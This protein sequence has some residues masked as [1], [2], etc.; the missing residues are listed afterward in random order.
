LLG[1][2]RFRLPHGAHPDAREVAP[3]AA[4][5][6]C[7]VD[8]H[9]WRRAHARLYRRPRPRLL[10]HDGRSARSQQPGGDQA[11]R[12]DHAQLHA[13]QRRGA[14]APLAEAAARAGGLCGR[15]DAL[16][17]AARLS[18]EADPPGRGGPPVRHL[19]VRRRP[20]ELGAGPTVQGA[21]SRQPVRRGRELLPVE[22]VGQ[23]VA[24]DHR[25]RAP[26]RRSSPRAPR[27]AF[28]A[29]DP[30]GVVAKLLEQTGGRSLSTEHAAVR[31]IPGREPGVP[32]R[33]VV[34]FGREICGDL[35]SAL[36]REWL[37]TNG[38]G[39]YASGTLAGINARRYHG[40]LVAALTP[41][42]GRTVLVGGLV[43]W[44]GYGGGRYPLSTHE[45]VD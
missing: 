1:R 37:V 24:D 40:L 6:G 9:P 4:R 12:P 25:Q 5:R 27:A 17:P 41:P 10:D 20:A 32:A 28:G 3:R 18:L 8:S 19:P 13:E 34:S 42:V 35:A 21:R 44:A 7:P 16:H 45:Y 31:A 43:E 11:G 26:D 14:P 15:R 29:A 39:G 2:G 33:P 22:F 38:L 23:P 36:R 30:R